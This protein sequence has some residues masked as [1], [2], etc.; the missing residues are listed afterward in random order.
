MAGG[1]AAEDFAA[2]GDDYRAI[3]TT[4]VADR[5][6]EAF[7]ERLHQIVRKE[8][9]GYAKDET[10][11]ATGL[12]AGRYVGIRPA[13]GY[14]AQPDHTVKGTIFL[15]SCRGG[16]CRDHS[17]RDVRHVSGSVDLRLVFLPSPVNLFLRWQD[18]QG[19]ACGLRR[20]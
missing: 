17:Y 2:K 3:M 11:D 9:W 19:S 12:L 13:P 8:I 1:E 7:A 4:L 6:T 20:P 5:L 10:A 16:D 18:Q 15:P 14:P